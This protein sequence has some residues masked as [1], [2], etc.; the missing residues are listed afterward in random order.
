MRDLNNYWPMSLEHLREPYDNGMSDDIVIAEINESPH[1]GY[2][3]VRQVRTAL[4]PLDVLDDVL[5]SAGGIGYEVNSWGPHPSVD[6][7]EIYE[8]SFQIDGRKGKEDECFQ[9]IINSWKTHDREVV[10]PDNILLM[11]YGLIPRHLS[12]GT[13]CWDDPQTSVYDVLRVK[14]YVDYSNK[15]DLPFA[16]VTIRREYLEDYCHLKR[17]AAVAVYYE[18]RYSFA[19]SSFASILNGQEREQFKLPGRLLD[20]VNTQES[21]APQRSIVSGA[22]LI[23]IP[24]S[25]PITDAAAPELI[26]PDEN[27]PMNYQRASVEL[28]Y[29]Y[30]RDE[31]LKEYEDHPEFSICPEYGGVS[32][33]RGWATERTTRV[34]RNHIRIELKKLYESCPPHVISHWHRFAVRE[35]VA[36][37]DLDTHGNRNIATR[38][39]EVIEGYLSLTSSLATLASNIGLHYSQEDIGILTREDIDY[40]GWWTFDVVRPLF[41]VA[42]L[43]ANREQFL[44]RTVS[45]N[46]LLELLKSAPLRAILERL[47]VPKDQIKGIRSLKMVNFICQLSS[48]ANEHG[49]ILA[50]D[51]DVV[52][53]KWDN[54]IEIMELRSIFALNSLRNSHAHTPSSEQDA[55]IVKDAGLLEI[56]VSGMASGWG[57]GIDKLYDRL[58]KDLFEVSELIR[59]GL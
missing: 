6:E 52:I 46:K 55:K 9:T 15:K 23:L 42:P 44:A 12:D 24:K 59:R 43:S 45:L 17:C 30:V 53:S 3:G 48:I 49:Y 38:A 33:K 31:V 2:E 57:Y 14:S 56:D 8:T 50:Q 21:I 36:K 10:L 16:S 19:D 11:T 22:R 51:T 26:W 58:A 29:G 32:Y 37:H 5:K 41:A 40:Q 1:N 25:R 13:I 39:K 34:G 27:K 28:I 35:A 47:G 7:G 54:K 18:E 4:I 20:L